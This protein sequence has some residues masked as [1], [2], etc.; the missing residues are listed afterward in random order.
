MLTWGSFTKICIVE[1]GAG[2]LG[3]RQGR[4]RV[5]SLAVSPKI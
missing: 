5:S 2:A 1:R 4:R 3:T